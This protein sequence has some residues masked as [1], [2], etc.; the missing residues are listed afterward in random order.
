MT[1]QV[2]PIFEF[3]AVLYA[4]LFEPGGVYAAFTREAH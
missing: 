3:R 4:V 1:G 2:L